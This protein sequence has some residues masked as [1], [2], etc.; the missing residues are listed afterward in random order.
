MT[1]S[2]DLEPGRDRVPTLPWHARV[3]D[4]ATWAAASIVASALLFGGF[5]LRAAGLRVSMQSPWRVILVLALLVAV[6][7]LLVRQ[8]NV[9]QRVTRA[10]S[11][12]R[13]DPAV[14]ESA[15]V[16]VLMRLPVIVAGYFAVLIVGYPVNNQ[17]PFR[18]S[19]DELINLP[20]RWDGGW[21]RHIAM[22]GYAFDAAIKGQQ[23]I[24]FFPAYPMMMRYGGVLLGARAPADVRGSVNTVELRSR[25]DERTAIAGWLVA[26]GASG[27]AL[28][29]LFRFA[30]ETLGG[31]APAGALWLISAYPFAFYFGALYTE[32]LFLLGSVAALYHFRR[33]EYAPAIAWGLLVGLTRPNG[34]FLSVPLGVMALQQSFFPRTLAAADPPAR[35]GLAGFLPA[36]LV[37]AMPGVGMLIFTGWLYEFT[38]QAF[39]WMK[40]HAAWG[41]TFQGV[42]VLL[43][44]RMQAISEQGL[45]QYSRSAPLEALYVV[46]TIVAL[47]S[48]WPVARRLG[49]GYAV[50]IL[51]TILP[52]LA[53]G[54]FLSMGRIISTIFPVFVYWGWRLS[55]TW[56]VYVAMMFLALQ[57]MLAS[58]FYTWYPVF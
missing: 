19:R 37:A 52:P 33:L 15:R 9:L 34:C 41:R 21:Y 44:E 29:Y 38:G 39:A 40:A 54:G 3:L 16:F 22:D 12:W 27:L 14:I 53:A 5:Q 55:P 32:G 51:L 25:A 8:P 30:R 28:V 6:R 17:P 50:L 46:P 2:N 49:L 11:R 43:T 1:P 35:P 24:A 4:V 42:E 13:R 58:A 48:T 23:N 45:Y 26:L 47:A 7:H 18:V 57:G 31:E 36:I 20:A 56:R 10:W